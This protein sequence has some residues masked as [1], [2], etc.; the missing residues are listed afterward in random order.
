MSSRLCQWHEELY[1]PVVLRGTLRLG[2][3]S[4]V[5]LLALATTSL[6]AT[7]GA[8]GRFCGVAKCVPIPRALAI[9]L[10]QRNESFTPASAPRPAPFFRIRIKARGEG[11]IDRTVIWVPSRKLWYDKQ[12]TIPPL[13]GFWRTESDR[14]QL[15]LLAR[16][17]RPFP[18]PAHWARV[19]PK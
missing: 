18:A 8:T 5:A 17:T 9:S 10:S 1:A 6:A 3:C 15:R 16:G 12:Y 19:L 2:L 11:Y 4:I 7:E 14:A 13:P